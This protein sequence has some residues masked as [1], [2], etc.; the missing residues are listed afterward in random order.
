MRIDTP[1]ASGFVGRRVATAVMLVA[2][3]GL[4]AGCRRPTAKLVPVEGV[5]TIAGTPAADIS[6][7][8]LPDAAEGAI[9]PTSVAVTD[10]E[11]RFSLRTYEGREGAVAGGHTVLLSDTLE[12]RPAQG[13]Q[14]SR[15]PRLD[16]RY[17]TVAGGIRVEVPPAG[18]TVS[19]AVP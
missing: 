9:C 11:G 8:F 2:V 18:G 12:E 1:I 15:P 3:A 19:V 7:Q 13:E 17:T 6:V 16:S 14:P 10:A 5:V 4:G